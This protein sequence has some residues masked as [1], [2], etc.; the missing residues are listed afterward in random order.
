MKCPNCGNELNPNQKFCTKCGKEVPENIRILEN[1]EKDRKLELQQKI[2]ILL[3]ALIVCFVVAFGAIHFIGNRSDVDIPN[4]NENNVE[5]NNNQI[6]DN[7]A[8]NCEDVDVKNLV[9]NIYKENDYY[10]KYI[11]PTSIS[12]IYL[13]SPVATKY[14][15]SIDK[16]SCKGFVTLEA[17]NGFRP[18]KYEF[19]NNFYSKVHSYETIDNG[20]QVI[21]KTTKIQCP[22]TYSSQI[23]EGQISVYSSYCNG[24]S[25]YDNGNTDIF[26]YDENN[27]YLEVPGSRAQIQKEERERKQRLEK[28]RQEE[29]RRQKEE[30]RL[31]QER[32][33]EEQKAR[34]RYNNSEEG[35][36]EN[37][38]KDLF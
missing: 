8:R 28:E 16:Y 30:A 4:E 3:V 38:E 27:P 21:Q 7:S 2:I 34:E 19:S 32:I 18:K 1:V 29:L 33:R 23:S 35:R 5:D 31:E 11:D 20:V 22:V 37:A 12:K 25:F 26:T 6:F 15:R 9:L 14:E 10:Y 36:Y 17:P 13:A 24:G